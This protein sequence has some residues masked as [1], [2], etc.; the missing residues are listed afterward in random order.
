MGVITK[1]TKGTVIRNKL[2]KLGKDVSIYSIG[3]MFAKGINFFSVLIYSRLL[4]ESEVGA[5]G[6]LAALIAFFV[7]TFSLGTENAYARYFFQYKTEQEKEE[8]TTTLLTFIGFFTITVSVV[9]LFYSREIT[10]FL[11]DSDKDQ[12]AIIFA[13]L[14]IPLRILS[15]ILNQVLRNQYKTKTFTA[16]NA[17]T[18]VLNFVFM[19]LLLLYTSLGIISFFLAIFLSFLAM[20]PV[21]F[22]YVREY[23]K[24]PS[25]QFK[26]L[27]PVLL[28]GLPFVPTL[29]IHWVLGFM[30]R[31]M[32]KEMMS[33]KEVGIY[34]IASSMS[35]IIVIF[36]NAVGQ[37][38]SPHSIEA[39]EN[40]KEE[41]FLLYKKFLLILMAIGGGFVLFMAL[42]GKELI[43]LFFEEKYYTAF[44]PFL[45][46]MSGLSF[47]MTNQVTALG[48]S[49]KKKTLY[50]FYV[51]F[52]AAIVNITMNWLL[53]P[54]FN[55]LGAAIATSVSYLIITN[56]YMFISGKLIPIQF[57]KSYIGLYACFILIALA[58]TAL[59][60]EM[61]LLLFL[62]TSIYL[63]LIRKK[64][65][66]RLL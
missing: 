23:M 24:R 17:V 18:T 61:R 4:T 57:N 43:M 42:C 6:Y 32:L 35:T 31:M 29:V 8:L 3:D 33:L 1:I 65:I 34:T 64:I 28:F 54:M 39:Y 41:A 22:Y 46:L 26:F 49:L 48:I 15:N 37:A 11:F 52:V 38:W 25:I 66:L 13:T 5:Y 30:D 9:L 55:E 56:I 62:G 44:M 63:F 7:G 21:R 60:M 27:K 47:Q 59:D 58:L 19:T 12:F 10:L 50:F 45:I 16:I 20:L 53:I 51:S 40:N 36:S 14:A 2:V